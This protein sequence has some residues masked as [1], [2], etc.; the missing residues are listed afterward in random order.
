MEFGNVLLKLLV[1][2]HDVNVDSDIIL[3]HAQ[4]IVMLTHSIVKFHSIVLNNVERHKK[5]M[6]WQMTKLA[7][8]CELHFHPMHAR[9]NNNNNDNPYALFIIRDVINSI[10]KKY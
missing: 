7:N 5:V 3:V 10:L 1:V 9:Q 6:H 4:R 8:K 2:S